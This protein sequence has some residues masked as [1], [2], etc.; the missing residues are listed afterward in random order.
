MYDNN[1]ANALLIRGCYNSIH[2]LLNSQISLSFLGK[3]TKG[4]QNTFILF[5]RFKTFSSAHSYP[6]KTC[7]DLGLQLHSPRMIKILLSE[8][9]KLY[10]FGYHINQVRKLSKREYS[11]FAKDRLTL[12]ESYS[13]IM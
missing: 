9:L 10:L 4:V 7:T 12:H 6:I 13:F 1:K 3:Q 5:V 2:L 11:I 8:Y